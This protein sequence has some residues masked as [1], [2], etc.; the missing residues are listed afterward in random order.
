[1][2][3]S[4][5][6]DSGEGIYAEIKAEEVRKN[7]PATTFSE[8]KKDLIRNL[9]REATALRSKAREIRKVRKS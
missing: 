8:E 7:D 2:R 1:M 5:Y 3:V 4:Y 9:L 6:S